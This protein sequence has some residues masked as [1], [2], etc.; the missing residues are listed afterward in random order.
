MLPDPFGISTIQ[1]Y[2]EYWTI[3][4][5]NTL[6]IPL[7][8]AVLGNRLLWSGVGVIAFIITWFGFS[9]NVV[10]D[11][12]FKKR[13]NNIV[14]SRKVINID[15]PKT[16]LQFGFIDDIKQLFKLSLFYCKSL[17]KEIPFIAITLVGLL[18]LIINAQNIDS[19]MGVH[20]YP[21]IYRILRTISISIRWFRRVMWLKRING[22]M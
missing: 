20:V 13:T 12:I 3:V 11:S 16:T 17:F 9:F 7:K 6:L 18:L 2:S 1:I 22:M 5:Q 21:T 10:R 8:G 4:E 15:I 14:V 19:M